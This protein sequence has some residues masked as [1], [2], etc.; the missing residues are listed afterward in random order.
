MSRVNLLAISVGN[1]RTRVGAYVDGKLVESATFLNERHDRVMDAISDA[2]RPLRDHQDAPVLMG[3]VNPTFSNPIEEELAKLGRPLHRVERDLPIP[4]GRQLDPEALVGEDRLLNA[5]GAF[6][7]LKQALVVVDAGT[8]VTVDLV[9]GAGTFHGGAILPG[10]Q[11]MLDALASRA[12]LLPEVEFARPNEIVGH[13]TTEA[14]LT[15]VYHGL[16]GAVR[17]LIE[18]YADVSGQFPLVVATGGDA[19]LLFR[20]WEL[21][22]RIV[23]DLTLM[24]LEVTLRTAMERETDKP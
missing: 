2:I 23:P 7:V 6:D 4:I 22:D 8:A 12:A 9:D 11:M 15:G 13:S 19:D 20:E 1:T 16:R 18:R 3:S 5:A 24:G 14:M 10:A 17:E 21:V